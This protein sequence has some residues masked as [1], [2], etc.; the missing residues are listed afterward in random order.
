MHVNIMYIGS[1]K[2]SSQDKRT[3]T[4]RN[5][6]KLYPGG[7]H[8]RMFTETISDSNR[9]HITIH[10]MRTSVRKTVPV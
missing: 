9:K 2:Y 10:D 1:V 6:H 5:V 8:D 4:Y 3:Q 7:G